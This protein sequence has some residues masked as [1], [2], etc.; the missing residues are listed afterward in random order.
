MLQ[1]ES[2]GKDEHMCQSAGRQKEFSYV[3]CL[4][5]SGL[6]LP[7]PTYIRE[8]SRLGPP[9]QIVMSS[10]NSLPDHQNKV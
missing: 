1:F 8:G 5:Y 9:I 2:E 7:G 10:R 4:F 3:A 6:Q